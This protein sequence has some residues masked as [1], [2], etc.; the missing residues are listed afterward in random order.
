[1][2]WAVF[3]HYKSLNNHQKRRSTLFSLPLHVF[4]SF[5]AST[6][7]PQESERLQTECLNCHHRGHI[8]EV[9]LAGPS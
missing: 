7:V 8:R 9:R 6:F 3:E 1:M 5:V 2:N 4:L